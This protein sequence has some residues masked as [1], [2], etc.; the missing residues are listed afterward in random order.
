MTVSSVHHPAACAARMRRPP[1]VAVKVV[2]I[3]S[4]SELLNFLREVECLAA[5]RHPHIVPFLGA[6]LQVR[7][8]LAAGKER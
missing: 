4:D 1:K 5:L 3:R 7:L 6:V 8:L 2:S